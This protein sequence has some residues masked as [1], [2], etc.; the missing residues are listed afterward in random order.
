M[1][2]QLVKFRLNE[3]SLD[4]VKRSLTKRLND[5]RERILNDLSDI[6]ATKIRVMTDGRVKVE[7]II[8]ADK[9]KLTISAYGSEAVK[10]EKSIHAFEYTRNA[11]P[12][13]LGTMKW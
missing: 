4:L 13:I 9:S 11:L 6:V 3:K 2:R 10:L 5:Q 8:D 1:I 12:K 7:S